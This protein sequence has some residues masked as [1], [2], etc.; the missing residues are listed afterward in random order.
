MS[1]HSL[2]TDSLNL[3]TLTLSYC[4]SSNPTTPSATT[5]P[6]RPSSEPPISSPHFIAV[7]LRLLSQHL[8]EAGAH[9]KG[10]PLATADPTWTTRSTAPSHFLQPPAG[11][12]GPGSP[13]PLSFHLGV[14]DGA[15]VLWLRSLEPADAPVN[16]GTK[17]ALAIGTTRRL[18]HDE[19]ERVFGYCCDNLGGGAADERTSTTTAGE[20]GGGLTRAWTGMGPGPARTA[21]TSSERREVEVFVREKVRVESADPSLMSLASKLTALGHMLDL[22][23]RNLAAAMGEELE[24]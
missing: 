23:R 17:L 5:A 4:Y 12:R 3:L 16:L 10:P 11:P 24:D 18:D 6:L 7:Q 15:L 8:S 22:A 1:L 19:S 20:G 9:L 13:P 2:L 21:S 14:Q